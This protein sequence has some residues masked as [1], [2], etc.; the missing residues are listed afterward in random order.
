MSPPNGTRLPGWVSEPLQGT[1][2]HEM[3]FSHEKNEAEGKADLRH[4][5]VRADQIG[6]LAVLRE[7]LKADGYDLTVSRPSANNADGITLTVVAGP[8]SCEECLIS[9]DMLRRMA[10]D[11]LGGM[12]PVDRIELTYPSDRR[13]S[14]T[15]LA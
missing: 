2:V 12:F 3:D 14:M 7:M 13:P 5:S 6:A 10:A 4:A 8:D 1:I 9:K 11:M 15:D